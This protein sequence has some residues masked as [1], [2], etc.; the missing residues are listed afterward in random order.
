LTDHYRKST[1]RELAKKALLHLFANNKMDTETTEEL[2][3]DWLL[4]IE[5]LSHFPSIKNSV[6]IFIRKAIHVETSTIPIINYLQYL[7]RHLTTTNTKV[8]KNPITSNV[9]DNIMQLAMVN[10]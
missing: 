9:N 8:I 4:S 10:I 3:P 6:I 1:D 5:N 7:Y 2:N